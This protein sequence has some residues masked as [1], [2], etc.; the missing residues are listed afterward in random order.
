VVVVGGGLAGITAALDCA[1]AGAEVT[2]VEVRPQLGGAA[3]S[4]SRE[5]MWIDNGQHVFLRCCTAYRT[6]LQ[7]IG[8]EDDVVLQR[9]LSIPVLGP[10]G[11]LA[12]LR[13]SSLPA[14]L[15][16]AGSLARYAHL[17]PAQRLSVVRA[18]LALGKLDPD[19]PAVDART[20]GSWLEEHGQ[21]PAAISAL[22]DLI[23]RPTLNLPAAEASLA[24]AAFVFQKG[25]LR[26]A[27]AGD[28]GYARV[29]LSA[30]HSVRTLRALGEAGVEV[31]LRRRVRGIER[32]EDGSFVV[33][34]GA[35][36]LEADAV[37]LAVPHDRVAEL[38]PAPARAALDRASE[39]GGSPI[40][41][42]HVVYDRRVTDLPFAA[43]LDGPVQWFFDRTEAAEVSGGQY[44]ALSLSAADRELALRP[45][46]LRSLCLPALAELLPAAR[47][48]RVVRC[49]T[50]R[51]HSATFRAAP[52]MR[53]LRPPAQ[54]AVGGLLLAGAW[55]DTGWPATMEGAVR[56]GHAAAHEAL[57]F[58]ER[59]PAA[60]EAVAA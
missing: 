28:V 13:R 47:S 6:F 59:A 43:T 39:L 56:S 42:L 31:R 49:F 23:A 36:P 1:E 8:A 27:G 37:V 45:D 30:V 54:T 24:L 50:T 20:F 10:T 9:R 60:R 17:R 57:G 7:R 4:F 12:W 29:P 25:L 33:E 22:W 11:R 53:A 19:D 46:E 18:A 3:Y 26:Q 2:L 48:A 51:E 38:V 16:L 58:F 15:H 21:S 32:R 35:E 34:A 52:G 55:T 41:N 44:L 5:G 40:V 14:P